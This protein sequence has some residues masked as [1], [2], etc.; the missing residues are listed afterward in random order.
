[1]AAVLRYYASLQENTRRVFEV[2]VLLGD[3]IGPTDAA[4][5]ASVEVRADGT[6]STTV[7]LPH[8]AS[9]MLARISDIARII[10]L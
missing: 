6:S 1:M 8:A 9:V 4:G 7:A 2:R 5:E 3:L 10:M